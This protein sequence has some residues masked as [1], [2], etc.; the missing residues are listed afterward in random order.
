MNIQ[1]IKIGD[2]IRI[3]LPECRIPIV[4]CHIEAILVD[5]ADGSEECNVIVF[6][7]W[8]KFKKRWYWKA[9]PYWELAIY[10]DRECKL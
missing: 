1:D 4:L 7:Y 2:K 6:R 3:R 5:P 10:N 8:S 9:A